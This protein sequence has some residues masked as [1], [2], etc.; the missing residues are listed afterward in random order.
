MTIRNI[1]VPLF[2]GVPFDNQ[3][4]VAVDLARSVEGHINA[5]FVRPDPMRIIAAAPAVSIAAGISAAAI[6]RDGDAAAAAAKKKFERWRGEEGLA[7]SMAD[8]S[9][10]TPHAQWSE[11]MGD[12]PPI[13]ASCGRLSDIIVIN[14]PSIS[15]ASAEAF[16]A[17][18]FESGR[19]SLLVDKKGS[20]DLLRHVVIAWNGSIE[21]TRAVAGAMTLLDEARQVSI[22]TTLDDGELENDLDLAESLCWHGINPRYLRPRPG[23]KSAA[24]ALLRVL[25]DVNPSMLVMG[26]YTHSRLREM[27][28]GGV[29]REVL[30]HAD[31][32]VLMTH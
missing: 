7:A 26:A 16:D 4:A 17:A 20:R 30:E 19:P 21:A 13:V 6:Q 5:V 18:V 1:F 27:L 28:L 8:R 10:R 15:L 23:E 11:R 14:R 3:L 29:T 2:P 32:P 31:I 24:E 9:P 22:F 12:I 25:G